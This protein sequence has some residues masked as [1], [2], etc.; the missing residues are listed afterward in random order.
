M[1][2]KVVDIA[3]GENFTAYNGDSCEIL[4]GLPDDS[5]DYSVYSPPFSDLYAYSDNLE[6]LSNCESD[7]EFFEHYSF[8]VRELY[9]S[10]K[11]GRLL[12][13]HVMNLTKSI[14]RD[15]V[16]GL[17]DF[18]G[19]VI[20]C[21]EECGFIFHSEVCIWK[22]PVTAM[23][24][25]KALGLL[26][27]QIVKDSSMS[28]Q[29]LPDYVVTFRKPG[30][31]AEPIAGRLDRF[32]GEEESF[33]NTGDYSI[34]VWQRYASPVWMDIR[35]T[36]TLNNYREGRGDGDVRHIAPL[37]LDVIDRCLQLWSNPGD[38]VL[39]P[40]MGIGS[41]GHESLLMGRRFVGIELKKSYF[42]LAVKNLQ[43]AELA[44]KQETLF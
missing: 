43:N 26:H 2:T 17:R 6:C 15:G 13:A 9:R 34:D 11:P 42:D 8:I 35:Q 27:K 25:T 37:Q 29:G 7:D 3:K 1:N 22:D 24:R 10:L 5:I 14:S 39:S 21:H 20:R 28:R 33:K 23:Q 41:E 30:K 12:S 38:V 31:N 40:F 4:Q 36:R 32:V 19:A 18:R 16:I 44:A